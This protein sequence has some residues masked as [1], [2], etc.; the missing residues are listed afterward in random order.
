M[1]IDLPYPHKA[2]WPNGRAHWAVKAREVK[3]H[4]TWAHMATLEAMNGK[5]W[6]EVPT[7]IKIIVHAKPKG[8]M[9][10]K[11][12]CVAAAKSLI[13]G[14]ADGLGVNDKDFPAPTVEF[15]DERDGRF[16]I[17][18]GEKQDG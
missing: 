18:I 8:P 1:Q 2:L 3:R 9:P 7:A 15:A 5:G 12:N 13:D 16:V 11:D 14:I 6:G 17:E 4:R 10:D